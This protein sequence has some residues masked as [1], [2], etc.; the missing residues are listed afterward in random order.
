MVVQKA[1]SAIEF[2]TAYSWAFLLIL[3]VAFVAFYYLSS[4]QPAPQCNFGVGMP[5]QTFKFFKN[6][7]GGMRLV[8][9]LNNGMGKVITFNGTQTVNVTNVGKTGTNSYAGYCWGTGTIVREGDTVYCSFNITDTDVIPSINKNVK[10]D[11]ALNYVDC[12]TSP[13][14]PNSCVGGLNRT[15]HGAITA[16]FEARPA[17]TPSYCGDGVCT[18]GETCSSCPADCGPCAGPVCL[19]DCSING[20]C[21]Q[22]CIGVNGCLGFQTACN[23]NSN[24]SQVCADSSGAISGALNY[25]V[26]CCNGAL[27]NATNCYQN[28]QNTPITIGYCGDGDCSANAQVHGKNCSNCPA[29]CPPCTGIPHCFSD[30]TFGVTG[31]PNLPCNSSCSSSGCGA[32]NQFPQPVCDTYTLNSQKCTNSIGG[33]APEGTPPLLN[34]YVTCCLGAPRSLP[35]STGGTAPPGYRC[36]QDTSTTIGW[37]GDTHCDT[38]NGESCVNCPSDCAACT[39]TCMPDCTFNNKCN[40][41]CSGC[42][43]IF[44]ACNGNVGANVQLCTD[45]SG[46]TTGTINYNVSCC[47]GA[48]TSCGNTSYCSSGSCTGC[49]IGFANCNYNSSDACEVN[50]LTNNSNCGHC[51]N[52]CPMGTACQGG[53]CI[54]ACNAACTFNGICNASCLGQN[55]CPPNTLT[56]WPACDKISKGTRI[57]SNSTGGSDGRINYQIQCCTGSIDDCGNMFYCTG[58]IYTN[59]PGTSVNCN[60]DSSDACEVPDLNTNDSNCGYCGNVCT[61]GTTCVGGICTA[62]TYFY[63]NTTNLCGYQSTTTGGCGSGLTTTYCSSGKY[64][65]I[66]DCL[67]SGYKFCQPETSSGSCAT[68]GDCVGDGTDTCGIAAC[69]TTY[70]CSTSGNVCDGVG[71]GASHC[72]APSSIEGADCYCPEMCTGGLVCNTTTHKCSRYYQSLPNLC[73][74]YNGT[75]ST[76]SSNP[77]TSCPA[78]KKVSASQPTCILG[79]QLSCVSGYC[80]VCGDCTGTGDT[81]GTKSC[82]TTNGYGCTSPSVCNG[83]GT[84]GGNCVPPSSTEGA[85]CYCPE[86]CTGGLVCNTTT[87]KCSR[88]YQSLPNLCGYYYGNSASC[89]PANA[90]CASG[91]KVSASQPTCILGAQLSCV[92]GYCAVCGDCTGTGDTCGTKSCGTTNG[93]GC[94][95]PSVCNGLGTGGGNCVPPSSTEG[96]DCYCPEMCTGGL[97]CNTTTHKCSRYYQSLPNLCGYY[98]GNSASCGPANA[99]CASG[100]KVSAS[101]P[102]CI[103]GAQLSCVSGYCAVCGDCTGTG[104]TCGTK[105][106]GTTN[107]YGCTS[108]SVCNGLGTGGGNCVA[109]GGTGATCYCA[110]MCTSGACSGNPG[111]CQ[112]YYANT[113]SLCGYYFGTLATCSSNPITNCDATHYF[114]TVGCTTTTSTPSCTAVSSTAACAVCGT[115]SSNSCNAVACGATNN[116]K[117][118]N[119]CKGGGTGASYCITAGSLANGQACLCPGVC[120]SG[121]CSGGTCQSAAGAC[122]NAHPTGTCPGSQVCCNCDNFCHTGTDYQCVTAC[123]TLYCAC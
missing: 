87:H 101:Q 67:S 123:S 85:D 4:Q 12:E 59:C 90:F 111:V 70:G 20:V 99:F 22:S 6:S 117:C 81:C 100:Y 51:G 122:D 114:P 60:N 104:D 88:Y 97:V 17:G 33:T 91:Y 23:G 98:Y 42:S 119:M 76:C 57:C 55:G 73:A 79:A 54:A 71:T 36:Y 109:K 30:C 53:Q 29:D 31:N 118:A 43:S 27:N 2:I 13:N 84:G 44:P 77:I 61:G 35:N 56:F 107:G 45:S 89:G 49:S 47:N 94:T 86:M 64:F 26:Q 5:C 72:A 83:L 34:Y 15:S 25:Y 65:P 41:T 106:C 78:S 18:A 69:G 115:C 14:Y 46:G 68:C 1:Q 121:T 7:S 3:L 93:Y 66:Q 39:N 32:W 105:S 108:P 11:V 110:G 63:R 112:G 120:Q 9:Q 24:K 75:S 74:Y 19:S 82:G 95:S 92:S 113:P 48:I 10:F 116:Y 102:T 38:A 40:A 8:F 52:V 96:A 28:N 103:L 50:L 21:N 80:A 62:Q 58:G 37:C 16:T